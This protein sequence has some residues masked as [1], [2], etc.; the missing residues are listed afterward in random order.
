MSQADWCSVIDRHCIDDKSKINTLKKY[1]CVKTILDHMVSEH[2]MKDISRKLILSHVR[3]ELNTRKLAGVGK[4]KKKKAKAKRLSNLQ[5][6][7]LNS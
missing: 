3:Q 4:Q 1:D 7:K 6:S 5:K 2:G